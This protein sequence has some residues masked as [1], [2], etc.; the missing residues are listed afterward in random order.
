MA[1]TPS[2]PARRP[3]LVGEALP[4]VSPH[5]AR[6][7]WRWLELLLAEH[8]SRGSLPAA[9][10]AGRVSRQSTQRAF[11]TSSELGR[12]RSALGVGVDGAWWRPASRV[13]ASAPA[14]G[15]APCLGSPS[16]TST[17]RCWVPR[18]SHRS[19]LARSACMRAAQARLVAWAHGQCLLDGLLARGRCERDAY[20]R[21]S[22]PAARTISRLAQVLVVVD[23][24][25][26]GKT[27]ERLD[28]W[29]H[30][31]TRKHF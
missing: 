23:E 8:G 13:A 26:S 15:A 4:R 21:P 2:P 3:E 16:S 19:A 27:F 29:P 18:L 20:L 14:P 5:G 30:G 11:I 31:G 24:D 6:A 22:P 10:R 25:G 7:R 17:G 12:R 28:R 1:S 9:F